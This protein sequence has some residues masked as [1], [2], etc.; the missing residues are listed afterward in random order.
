MVAVALYVSKHVFINSP[1]LK[2]GVTVFSG[3]PLKSVSN[4]Y[5]FMHI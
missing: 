3:L 2:L 5:G 1:D 4:M